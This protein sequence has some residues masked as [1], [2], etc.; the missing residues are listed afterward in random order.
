MNTIGCAETNACD[1]ARQG[2]T[3]YLQTDKGERLVLIFKETLLKS[4]FLNVQDGW[5]QLQSYDIPKELINK[6]PQQLNSLLAAASLQISQFDNGDHRLSLRFGLNGG[7][8]R[9]ELAQLSEIEG[10]HQ[11]IAQVEREFLS[12]PVRVIDPATGNLIKGGAAL[13]VGALGSGL[14]MGAVALL[15]TN[16]AGWLVMGAV[17]AVGAVV[18]GACG[19]LFASSELDRHNREA[20]QD[21]ARLNSLFEKYAAI[22]IDL[23]K[24]NLAGAGVKSVELYQQLINDSYIKNATDYDFEL[25]HGA[26]DLLGR[27]FARDKKAAVLFAAKFLILSVLAGIPTEFGEGRARRLRPTAAI[28]RHLEELLDQPDRAVDEPIVETVYFILG[29]LLY[30]TQRYPR[31]IEYFQR[32]SAANVE[33][34]QNA[35]LM[36]QHVRGLQRTLNY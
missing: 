36:V 4:C 1:S 28:I 20:E 30:K 9:R 23:E 32:I 22:Q 16:P 5:K 25:D 29:D 24:R 13:G 19:W 7:M 33:L 35:R 15:A 11:M 3:L 12:V 6:T 34:Q 10:Y 18:F 8:F 2:S 14:G 31:A 21:K 26:F 27:H 17:G